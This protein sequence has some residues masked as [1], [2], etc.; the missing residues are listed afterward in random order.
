MKLTNDIA[1]TFRR[2]L[3][4]PTHELTRWQRT[5]RW[6][7]ELARHCAGELRHDRAGQMAA[8]L[9]YHTV[10]S[11]L[12]TL[13]LMLVVMHVF[14]GE[15]DREQVKQNIVDFVVSP[16]EAE[17]DLSGPIVTSDVRSRPETEDPDAIAANANRADFE[18]QRLA[19]AQTVED[20]LNKL[21]GVN[22]RSIGYVGVL[23]FLWGATGLLS[24]IERSFNQLYGIQRSRPWYLRLPLYYTVIT[25]G[26][27]LMV[28]GL[29]IQGR[30]FH[31]IQGGTSTAWLAGPLGALMPLLTCWLVL[32]LMFVLLPN[33]SV[34]LRTA[35]VGSF[36]SAIAW[37]TGVELFGYY[38]T[39]AVA[40][41][42]LYGALGLLPLFL[43]WLWLS[44]LVLLF[45]LELAYTLQAMK[46]RKFKHEEH[47]A[48]ENLVDASWLIPVAAQI[49]GTFQHGK[50]STTEQISKHTELSQRTVQ[51]MIDAL[52]GA[53]LVNQVDRG[54]KSGY[55]LARPAEQ[56]KI[57]DVIH[58]A[59]D[60]LPSAA[61]QNS[62]PAW[63]VVQQINDAAADQTG[64][65]TLADLTAA[66]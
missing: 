6:A 9:T 54:S 22:F 44:W 27:L 50:V 48:A 40:V 13:V 18:Q 41:R 45:G 1:T 5:V 57:E 38:V 52:I 10:F 59:Q 17:S 56:I 26:P 12:P 2:L 20:A 47:R 35:A 42:N 37:V 33:T 29:L 43:L 30:M 32:Y 3:T 7:I 64:G 4:E 28:T 34:S 66:P 62:D 51:R 14:L 23:I 39:R 49:A 31:L 24:T 25:L 63:G 61:R 55:A 65:S 21:E 8:A 16:I 60:L 19:I 46:G 11:L 36:V 58:V 53:D 15:Q